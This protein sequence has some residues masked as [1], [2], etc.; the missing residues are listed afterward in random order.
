MRVRVVCPKCQGQS[1]IEA[2]HVGLTV[3]CPRCGHAFPAKAAPAVPPAPAAPR[4][5]GPVTL[6]I[7]SAIARGQRERNEDSL[8]VHHLTWGFKEERHELAILVVA[9]GLGGHAAGD[10]ASTIVVRTIGQA[11]AP[12]MAS[13]VGGQ[14]S[15]AGPA[16]LLESLDY[17]L[18][19]ANRVV[20]RKGKG[21]AASAGMAATAAVLLVWNGQVAIGHVGDC[22]VYLHRVGQL[23]QVTKD[24]TLVGRMVE[25]GTLSPAEAAV[26]P[27]RHQVLTAIGQHFDVKPARY[28][29]ALEPGDCLLAASDGLTA[30]L[31]EKEIAA[32]L[33]SPAPPGVMARLLVDQADKAG[34]S[35]NCTVIVVQAV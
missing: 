12:L 33:R 5:K 4:R 25:L 2:G 13:L 22:R 28:Q 9:D 1:Q 3:G 29:L 8:L 26:H 34:G 7:G 6:Q 17:A 19:E 14:F 35:D 23:R 21:D 24:Q 15:Q 30:D 11:L 27:D 32:R 20:Y 16:L 10:R 31:D 18:Q